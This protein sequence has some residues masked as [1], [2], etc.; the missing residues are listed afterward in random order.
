VKKQL[1]LLLGLVGLCGCGEK[2][3]M[4]PEPVDVTVTATLGAKPLP[5]SAKIMLRPTTVDQAPTSLS[6]KTDGQFTGKALPGK[7]LYTL[8]KAS[9]GEDPPPGVPAKYATASDENFLEVPP[10]GGALTIKFSN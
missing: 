7:Y 1:A 2:A 6:A 3:V 9:G 5:T 4:R 10:T 8:V